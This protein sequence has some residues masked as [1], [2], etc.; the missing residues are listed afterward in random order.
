MLLDKGNSSRARIALNG[1]TCTMHI[2]IFLVEANSL[3]EAE[4]DFH[5]MCLADKKGSCEII[6]V[7]SAHAT[8]KQ[9]S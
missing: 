4:G 3:A 1:V 2:I 5:V 6:G 9:I 8:E 7:I